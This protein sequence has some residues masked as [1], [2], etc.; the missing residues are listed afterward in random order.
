[1]VVT[2]DTVEAEQEGDNMIQ[3]DLIM[4]GGKRRPVNFMER[5]YNVMFNKKPLSSRRNNERLLE[6]LKPTRYKPD[7]VEQ[8]ARE[9]KFTKEEVKCLYRAFKQECPT[10]TWLV[11]HPLNQTCVR[12][13]CPT[14]RTF[15]VHVTTEDHVSYDEKILLVDLKYQERS[16]MV[17]QLRRKNFDEKIY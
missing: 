15:I 2:E 1:M 8:M 5:I 16:F 13:N 6:L 9:T 7:N 17:L 10:G 11:L 4:V 14:A 12:S 3:G